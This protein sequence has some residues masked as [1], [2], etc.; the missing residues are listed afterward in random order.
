MNRPL[1]NTAWMRFQEVN[2][3]AEQVGERI[4]GNVGLNIGSGAISNIAAVRLS[5][6]LNR[7]GLRIPRIANRTISGAD[8][9]WYFTRVRDLGAWLQGRFG[10]P[11]VRSPSARVSSLNRHRGL[12]IL[13]VPSW[14]DSGGHATLWNGAMGADRCDFSETRDAL[15]W[16]LR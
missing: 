9:S 7:G 5:Y 13:D 14:S 4:G 3:P 1:F 10:E 12:L 16:T 8:G 15:L 6:V 11:E 2:R